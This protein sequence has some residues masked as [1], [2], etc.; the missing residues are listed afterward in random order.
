MSLVD[1]RGPQLVV[2][3]FQRFRAGLQPGKKK[4]QRYFNER[5][6]YSELMSA[7]ISMGSTATT[8]GPSW[9]TYDTMHAGQR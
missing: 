2:P 5:N 8:H 6:E 1:V 3:A 9:T 4:P 7:E